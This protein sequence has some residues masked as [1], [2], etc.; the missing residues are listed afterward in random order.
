[1]QKRI[2]ISLICIFTLNIIFG[3]IIYD[4]RKYIDQF[5]NICISEAK[6]TGIPASIKMAQALIESAA[7][8]SKLALE[9]NN[10]FGIK[11]GSSWVGETYWVEDDEFDSLNIKKKSCFRVYTN[12]ENSFVAHSDFLTDPKKQSRYG[13]LFQYD[14]TDYR[15]WAFGL[16]SAG[17]ASNGDY[18]N[19]LI[20]VIEENGLY[21]LDNETI[22]SKP[23]PNIPV[24]S[25]PYNHNVQSINDVKMVFAREGETLSDIASAQDVE[26]VDL[27]NYNEKY[28]SA[29][30]KLVLGTPIFLQRKRRYFRDKK[31]EHYVKDGETMFSISQTYGIRLYRL[32]QKNRMPEGSEPVPGSKLSLRGYLPS[33]ETPKLKNESQYVSKKKTNEFDEFIGSIFTKNKKTSIYDEDEP[34][35]PG[36]LNGGFLHFEIEPTKVDA[37]KKSKDSVGSQ[38]SQKE[39][40]VPNNMHKVS[41]GETLFSISKK[42]GISVQQL[43][44]W[45]SLK[46]NAIKVGQLLKIKN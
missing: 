8:S 4:K 14:R 19:I 38:Y 18:A 2:L 25:S 41:S 40:P 33:Q 22:A 6:R 23:D 1:M 28:F 36:A 32:Y 21:L 39:E 45:N 46:D 15:N 9:S 24:K 5:K 35:F 37:P 31:S 20:K 11:C 13:F 43:K 10:H 17:Y 3:Q 16:K 42:Y 34:G 26:V 12:P 30:Q 44:D 27:Y 7:G 29:S